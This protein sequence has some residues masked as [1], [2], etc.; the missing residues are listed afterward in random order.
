WVLYENLVLIEHFSC[1][2]S[3]QDS[4]FSTPNIDST[5]KWALGRNS[6]DLISRRIDNEGRIWIETYDNGGKYWLLHR[7]FVYNIK[8]TYFNILLEFIDFYQGEGEVLGINFKNLENPNKYD[9]ILKIAD[10]L[11][12]IM[13]SGDTLPSGFYYEMGDSYYNLGA[14][15]LL[16]YAKSHAYRE[17]GEVS[18][19]ILELQK[20][21][22][23]YPD[24]QLVNGR[25]GPQAAFG[26]AGMYLDHLQDT[27]KAIAQY[28]FI[29]HHYPEMENGN[30]NEYSWDAEW[31]AMSMLRL[32]KND[33]ARL[34][35]EFES[36]ITESRDPKITLLGYAGKVRA[37]GLQ[38]RFKQMIDT[39]LVAIGR[40]PNARYPD[41]DS[42]A[43]QN[44]N[45]LDPL[46]C[47]PVNY[48]NSIISAA[49][50]ALEE[51]GNVDTF[52]ELADKIIARFGNYEIGAA[53]ALRKAQYAD[54]TNGD[55][56]KVVALYRRVL[57]DFANF[58]FVDRMKDD[59]RVESL[60]KDMAQERIKE[61]LDQSF[62]EVNIKKDATEMRVGFGQQFPVLKT[63]P[64]GTRVKFLYTEEKLVSEYI[65]K[66]S[67]F[68][69]RWAK[70]ETK[71]GAIGWVPLNQIE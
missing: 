22:K 24:Q 17:Q 64:M 61:L 6:A 59:K 53:A 67:R 45:E 19:S 49:F 46:N 26:L 31:A 42:A 1:E 47:D 18:K 29:I 62:S 44:L 16:P 20:I 37:L 33:P 5:F 27:T 9:L 50:V 70:I 56:A 40:Y 57:D 12:L 3:P 8:D 13:A 28:H 38:G 69:P 32:L 21:I 10:H 36:V 66:Y 55:Q 4:V 25:A 15:V 60:G 14:A 63:L 34:Y 41:I 11:D 2:T 23:E 52:P 39:A 58:D 48:S 54:R 68:E 35:R 43:M 65:I 30:C 51:K 71:D 7:K